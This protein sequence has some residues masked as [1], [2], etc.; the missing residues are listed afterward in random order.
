MD[1][2]KINAWAASVARFQN[3]KERF[4]QT[5]G[6]SLRDHAAARSEM[7]RRGRRLLEDPMYTARV[8]EDIKRVGLLRYFP[9]INRSA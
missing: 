2:N 7:I 8:R 4:Y 6:A 5:N 3:E 1:Q 9:S